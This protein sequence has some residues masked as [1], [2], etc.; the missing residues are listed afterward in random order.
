MCLDADYVHYTQ[1]RLFDGPVDMFLLFP[2][3]AV[4]PAMEPS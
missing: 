2:T 4:W 1:D 3:T